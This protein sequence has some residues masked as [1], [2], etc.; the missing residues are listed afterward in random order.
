M[1]VLVD[2]IG[3][4]LGVSISTLALQILAGGF[5][6]CIATIAY[7]RISNDE[8]WRLG[9]NSISKRKKNNSR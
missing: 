1:A 3:V 2:R 4:K 6:F 9:I 7:L 8:L 5:F